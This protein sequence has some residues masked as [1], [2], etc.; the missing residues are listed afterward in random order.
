M[1]NIPLVMDSVYVQIHTNTSVHIHT[2]TMEKSPIILVQSL[3]LGHLPLQFP[4]IESSFNF[5]NSIKKS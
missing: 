4:N 1:R 3:K 5:G 2:A